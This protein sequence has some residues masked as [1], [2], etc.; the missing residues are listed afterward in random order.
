MA[1]AGLPNEFRGRLSILNRP[2]TE[3]GGESPSGV[4]TRV[5][6]GVTG[7]GKRVFLAL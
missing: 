2:I 1:L 4:G 7:A 3:G 6:V 5:G